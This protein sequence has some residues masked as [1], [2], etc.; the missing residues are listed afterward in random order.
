MTGDSPP[1]Q[2]KLS[3]AVVM[4]NSNRNCR[5]HTHTGVCT[6]LTQENLC[7]TLSIRKLIRVI[8]E[9]SDRT[10]QQ[11]LS[12]SVIKITYHVINALEENNR[13]LFSD[14]YKT[15]NLNAAYRWNLEVLMLNLAVH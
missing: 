5:S 2:I 4:G 12:V 13:C 8:L 6:G 10:A 11:T 7:S 9:Y 14:V 1:T 3:F 15:H